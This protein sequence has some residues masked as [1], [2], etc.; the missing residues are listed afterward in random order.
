MYISA[1]FF[2][3]ILW[4][5]DQIISQNLPNSHYHNENNKNKNSSLL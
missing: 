5:N 1:K 4:R 3:Q 2:G